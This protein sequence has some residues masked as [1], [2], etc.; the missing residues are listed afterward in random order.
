MVARFRQSATRRF[1]GAPPFCC[2]LCGAPERAA[3]RTG[4]RLRRGDG[5]ASRGR[6]SVVLELMEAE[7][8]AEEEYRNK[9]RCCGGEMMG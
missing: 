3:C 8:D 1:A 5:G 6:S 7:Y 2:W 4:A 9:K